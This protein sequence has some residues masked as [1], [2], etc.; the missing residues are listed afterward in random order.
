MHPSTETQ[1]IQLCES[2]GQFSE[3]AMRQAILEAKEPERAE[4][5]MARLRHEVAREADDFVGMALCVILGEAR[6]RDAVPLLLD[7][8]TAREETCLRDAAS[9]AL[10]R[11]GVIALRAGMERITSADDAWARVLGYEVLQAAIDADADTRTRVAD[12]CVGRAEVETAC[13]WPEGDWDPAAAV[14]DTLVVLDDERV[15]PFLQTQESQALS[16]SARAM[17]SSM[18]A[19]LEAGRRWVVAPDWRIDW[20]EMCREWAY[21]LEH[22]S[23]MD[24][25][26]DES[27][28]PSESGGDD[29]IPGA[30]GRLA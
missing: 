4:T 20:P 25:A 26:D 10:C 14:C 24:L 12:F 19:D 8:A 18:L 23:G 21:L 2:V 9:Y 16:Q 27:M 15:R 3:A 17:W 22:P 30:N 11:M 29:S 5:L 7:V 13:S 6:A 28:H 1:V